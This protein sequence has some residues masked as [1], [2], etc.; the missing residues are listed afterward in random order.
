MP[1]QLFQRFDFFLQPLLKLDTDA[2]L[3]QD[4]KKL[5]WIA[6]SDGNVAQFAVKVG[7]D[8]IYKCNLYVCEYIVF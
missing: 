6:C 5:Q 2:F 8:T 3:F 7:Y 1:H 4:D